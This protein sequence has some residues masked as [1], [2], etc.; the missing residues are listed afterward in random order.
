MTPPPSAKRKSLHWP[1][2]GKRL[3]RYTTSRKILNGPLWRN[4]LFIL[5]SRPVTSLFP[6]PENL[7]DDHLMAFFS[8][9]SVQGYMGPI[10]PLGMDA[11][12]LIFAGLGTLLGYDYSY[13]E[14][15]VLYNAG[16]R[17]WVNI[18]GLMRHPLG[19][20]ILPKV[21]SMLD[22]GLVTSL[23]EIYQLPEA[24]A[25]Q[26]KLRLKTF[27]R[28]A[29]L[30]LPIWARAARNLLAPKGQ[31]DVIQSTLTSYLDEVREKANSGSP[32]ELFRMIYFG[33]VRI[34]TVFDPC[35][36][37]RVSATDHSYPHRKTPDWE[38]RSR[39]RDH[40]R[41]AA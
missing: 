21:F 5:Q 27:G 34:I 14:Q 16:E 28:I 3:Q 2:K 8:F 13:Q 12:R 23:E 41:F 15:K 6:V 9:A 4:E 40:P 39:V 22:P 31:L 32:T 10:T 36:N 18:T 7:P 17:L 29:K 30:A 25:G 11:L 20:K 37:C 19:A 1:K 38:W 33:F 24:E 26:G 35:N